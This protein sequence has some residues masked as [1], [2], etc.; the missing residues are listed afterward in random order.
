MNKF[1][2]VISDE[3]PASVSERTFRYLRKV[4][5]DSPGKLL[6]Q[7]IEKLPNE[8]LDN[9]LQDFR[10]KNSGQIIEEDIA[11]IA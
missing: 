6:N 1:Q 2:I 8:T 10:R 5:E 7:I 9:Y 4:H 3:T 11:I